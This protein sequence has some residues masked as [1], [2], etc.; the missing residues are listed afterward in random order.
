MNQ[1][2]RPAAPELQETLTGLEHDLA[3]AREELAEILATLKTS[4]PA[5][6]EEVRILDEEIDCLREEI[7]YLEEDIR[8]IEAGLTAP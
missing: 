8:E 4:P 6:P 7:S 5:D 2:D 3:Q 1:D